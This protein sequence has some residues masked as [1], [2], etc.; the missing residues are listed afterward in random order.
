MRGITPYPQGQGNIAE[1]CR[2]AAA[3]ISTQL[4]RLRAHLASLD[5]ARLRMSASRRDALLTGYDIYARM[6][7]DALH[8]I[9]GDLQTEADLRPADLALAAGG[10]R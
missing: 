3:G 1:A 6:L 4:D 7:D 8:D 2:D 9:A 5:P 10:S